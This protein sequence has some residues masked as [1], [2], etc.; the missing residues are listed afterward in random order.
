MSHLRAAGESRIPL[1]CFFSVPFVSFPKPTEKISADIG[2]G[3]G[4]GGK[5][6]GE[7]GGGKEG[8]G[9][10]RGEGRLR[11]EQSAGLL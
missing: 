10:R 5:G 11:R 4:G 3:R 7:R 8:E 6:G 2:G 9:G 1:L